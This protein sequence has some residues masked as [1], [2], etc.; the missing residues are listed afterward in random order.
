ML[1]FWLKVDHTFRKGEIYERIGDS[2]FKEDMKDITDALN[3][4]KQ[5]AKLDPLNYMFFLKQGKWYEKDKDFDSAI[6]SYKKSWSLDYGEDALPL[7]RL[8][9]AYIRTKD[10]DNGID[11]LIKASKIDTENVDALTKIGELLLR[12]DSTLD[13]AESYLK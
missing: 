11:A 9:W 2:Y 6:L 8:G 12:N 7:L 10:Y 1:I 3:N 4:Y 5:A 13:D